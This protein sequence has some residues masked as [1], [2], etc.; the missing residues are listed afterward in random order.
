[1]PT[2]TS[3]TRSCC[4]RTATKAMVHIYISPEEN[5]AEA[6]SFLRERLHGRAA[7]PMNSTCDSC[8]E[9]DWINNWKQYFKPIP[10]GEK[11]L[12]RPTWEEVEDA[13]GP[14]GAG[15]W[16]RAWPLAPAPT[17]PPACAWSCWSG[18]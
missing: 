1:M 7:F 12:I 9:E 16:T 8:V 10:V 18:M 3:L 5:P 15:T 2:S 17:R 4:R 6:V 13:A 11:L 14:H